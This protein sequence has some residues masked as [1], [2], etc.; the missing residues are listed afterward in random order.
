M[1]S[2]GVNGPSNF[3]KRD[4]RLSNSCL[5]LGLPTAKQAALLNP[6]QSAREAA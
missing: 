2:K 6:C 1:L 3:H 4:C 5:K